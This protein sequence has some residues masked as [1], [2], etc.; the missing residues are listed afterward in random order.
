MKRKNKV[1]V[2]SKPLYKIK[3]FL[4]IDSKV[5]NQLT[6]FKTYLP[7]IK[8]KRCADKSNFEKVITL[9]DSKDQKNTLNTII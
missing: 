2:D 3:K 7:I 9:N 8:P 5:K 6:N 4:K 1:F